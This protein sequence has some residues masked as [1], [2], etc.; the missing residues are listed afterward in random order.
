MSSPA[1]HLSLRQEQGE[2]VGKEAVD[3]LSMSETRRL[4]T[5]HPNPKLYRPHRSVSSDSLATGVSS[6]WTEQKLEEAC[7]YLRRDRSRGRGHNQCLLP[8]PLKH[9]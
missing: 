9:Q 1:G 7:P 6:V 4:Y 2:K 8:E 3:L 5:L